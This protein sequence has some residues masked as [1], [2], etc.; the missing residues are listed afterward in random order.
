MP[1]KFNQY[2]LDKSREIR[3]ARNRIHPIWRGVGFAFIV[4]I[5]ILS[6]AITELLLQQNAKSNWFPMPYDLMARPGNFLY[7]GDPLLYLKIILTVTIVLAFYAI[8]MLITFLI[9]SAFGS[10]RYG[11]YD[12][13]P[14]NAKVRRRAR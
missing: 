7:N 2:Q 14:I 6:Y 10:P 1:N 11:P 3:E 9:N 12:V 13:P 8:F 5:P 4:L